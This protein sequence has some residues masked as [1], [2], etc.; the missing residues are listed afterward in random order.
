MMMLYPFFRE[1][2]VTEI[3]WDNNVINAKICDEIYFYEDKTY[4][5]SKQKINPWVL[6]AS[7]LSKVQR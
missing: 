2:L 4:D 7:V 1:S 6:G 5:L 3:F